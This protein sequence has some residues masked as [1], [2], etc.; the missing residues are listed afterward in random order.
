LRD[1]VR[2]LGADVRA[3]QQAGRGPRDQ[4]DERLLLQIAE[5]STSLP[6]T[7]R[8]LFQ[9]VRLRDDGALREALLHADIVSAR[10]LGRFLQR[11][12]GRQGDVSVT[13]A[14]RPLRD[15]AEW[16]VLR[17]SRE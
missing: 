5:S 2:A 10:Q 12:I 8:G 6:F 17:E 13:R 15:G 4:Q 9:H 7:C 14:R 11:C 16:Q 1:Q 3:L